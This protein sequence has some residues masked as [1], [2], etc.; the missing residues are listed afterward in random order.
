MSAARAAAS[1]PLWQRRAI[2]AL[3]AGDLATGVLLVISPATVETLLFLRPSPAAAAIFVRWVGVF[4]A[5]VG[6]AYLLPF[7]VREESAR[8]ERLRFVLEWT[9]WARLAVATFV[10]AAVLTAALPDGWCL[11]GS[12]DA[13]AASGQLA[14]LASWARRDAA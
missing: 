13:L 5:A 4:V 11:V 1:P 10:G 9:A 3:G 12:Y 8:R 2:Q 6:A 14:L 7:R